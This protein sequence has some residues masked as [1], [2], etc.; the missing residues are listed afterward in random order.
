M[1]KRSD[2]QVEVSGSTSLSK[3]QE[4]SRSSSGYYFPFTPSTF[5]HHVLA[6]ALKKKPERG[7]TISAPHFSL[8]LCGGDI[9]SI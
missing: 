3:K 9:A 5:A 8:I 2:T 4:R 1:R 6:H 7:T